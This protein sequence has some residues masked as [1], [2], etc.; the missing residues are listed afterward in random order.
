MCVHHGSSACAGRCCAK[1]LLLTR[2]KCD[3]TKSLSTFPGEIQVH[4]FEGH[5]Y[6][7]GGLENDAFHNIF[8]PGSY[9]WLRTLSV[10]CIQ[11]QVTLGREVMSLIKVHSGKQQKLHSS[12]EVMSDH[13]TRRTETVQ[14]FLPIKFHS[15]WTGRKINEIILIIYYFFKKI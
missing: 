14:R 1:R 4:I 11:H 3:N 13:G 15:S 9:A 10:G 2:Y 6:D 7:I 5:N 8:F 12:T